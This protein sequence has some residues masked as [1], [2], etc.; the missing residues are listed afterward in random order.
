MDFISRK[1]VL[2][3]ISI[4]VLSG[5]AILAYDLFGFREHHISKVIV[6]CDDIHENIGVTNTRSLALL[7]D[8]SHN[9]VKFE[10]TQPFKI[11]NFFK[12]TIHVKKCSEANLFSK[13][14]MEPGVY[15]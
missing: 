13:D 1:F 15:V 11:E 8:Y 14:T 6:F 2:Y 7:K 12:D 9:K 10:A 3:I 4:L 5:A